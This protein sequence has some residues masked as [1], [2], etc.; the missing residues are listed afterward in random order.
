MARK[1]TDLKIDHVATDSLV[2]YA[3]NP[4][5]HS[6]A[7][8]AQIAA[9]M[10]E[11]GWTNPILVDE[12]GGIIAGHGRLL[13]ARKLGMADV[14]TIRLAG[15][16]K[17]QRKA[18]VI[19]DNKLALNAGWDDDM[20]TLEISELRGLDFDLTLTGFDI[21]ELDRMDLSIGEVALPSLPSGD[22]PEFQQMTF[23]LH[24]S[25][26][27]QVKAAMDVAKAMGG[28][29][30]SPNENSNGNALARVCETF[31]TDHGNG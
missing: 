22:K 8:V 5:T 2:P 19:A 18:L 7:Q 1:L 26:A 9:S 4:R 20:L 11:F 25:Q 23:T 21:D 28:F 6:D 13:A 15:L 16:T 10:R 31:L 24:D 3:R 17:A 30:G 14:P 29:S 27:E 12:S